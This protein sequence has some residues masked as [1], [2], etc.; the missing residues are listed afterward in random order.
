MLIKVVS[1][2]IFFSKLFTFAFSAMN[3]LF[4]TTLLSTTSLNFFEPTGTIFNL[5][6]S[7]SST[8]LFELLKLLGTLVSL[9]MSILSTLTFKP[10][11]SFLA[12]KSDVPMPVA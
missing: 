3:F 10:V 9:L 12:A 2:G 5:P 7:K 11:K 8:F 1:S 4:L 6:T